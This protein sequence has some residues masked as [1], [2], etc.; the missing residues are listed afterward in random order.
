MGAQLHGDMSNDLDGTPN[1]VCKVT[2]FCRTNKSKTVHFRD[3][4]AE[5]HYW[6]TIHHLSDDT[7]LNDLQ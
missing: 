2:A 6:E 1:R 4:I 3:E 5:Q 7:S